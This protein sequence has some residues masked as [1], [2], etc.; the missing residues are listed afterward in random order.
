MTSTESLLVTAA[1]ALIGGAW[2]G[3]L[4]SGWFSLRLKARKRVQDRRA[5]VYVDM[6]AWVG[7]RVPLSPEQER[8][9]RAE[10]AAHRAGLHADAQ[11]TGADGDTGGSGSDGR[12]T[13]PDPAATDPD[14][15]ATDPDTDFFV[16]LRSRIVAFGSH[17]MTRAFDRWTK[18]YRVVVDKNA[19]ANAKA[20]ALRALMPDPACD[21]K[22]GLWH[23]LKKRWDSGTPDRNPGN[24][25][26]AIEY[27]AASE[28]RKG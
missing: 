5:L 12:A 9:A 21:K 20:A 16:T 19:Y 6:L 4:I 14:T 25:T 17:D 18:E 24:L 27:C 8:S 2:L 7:R 15:K 22:A 1:V 10:N 26:R 11:A 3:A 23:E 28:L 13:F